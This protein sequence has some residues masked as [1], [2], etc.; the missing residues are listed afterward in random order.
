MATDIQAGQSRFAS[1]C[2]FCH[3]RDAQGGES[4]PDLTRSTLVA[5]D[6]HGDKI[7]PVIR[8]GRQDKGMP[9]FSLSVA[10]VAAIVAFIH[11]AKSKAESA[12]GGRRSVEISDLQ[13]GHVDAGK[14]YFMGAG[15][16]IE[17]HSLSGSF[18]SIGSRFQG[19]ALLQ[20]ML[21]PR[22]GRGA[23][24]ASAL[25]SVTIT[26]AAGEKIT[27]KLTYR[28]EF[29]L[30]LVDPDGWSHTW[31]AASVRITSDDPLGAH[32]ELLARYTDEEMHDVFAFLQTLK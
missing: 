14:R 15:G 32:A 3:G 29:S 5:G 30:T 8:A 31:P 25:P 27:G 10:E 28:D 18:A 21:Y 9:S 23:R 19:L 16:C 11:D 4:G 20:R 26:A 13:T 12:A 7:G 1:Q 2:G 17:C 24:M 22:S 6:D